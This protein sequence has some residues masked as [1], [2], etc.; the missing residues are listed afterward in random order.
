ML[1]GEP[2]CYECNR[3]LV[4]ERECASIV[5]SNASDRLRLFLFLPVLVVPAESFSFNYTSQ[6]GGGRAVSLMCMGRGLFPKPELKLF[7][8]KSGHR[9]PAVVPGVRT[10]TSK[11]HKS[12]FDVVLHAEMAENKLPS[13]ADIFECVL[14]IPYSNYVLTRRMSLSSG[15]WTPPEFLQRI[16]LSA[17][18]VLYLAFFLQDGVILAF[19]VVNTGTYASSLVGVSFPVCFILI[20]FFSSCWGPLSARP[21]CTYY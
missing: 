17:F 4:W 13:V 1:N 7:V 16:F 14:E 5:S 21:Q 2:S 12:L 6:Q 8:I 10:F 3:I 11:S 9:K 18:I 15:E 19:Y 20:T